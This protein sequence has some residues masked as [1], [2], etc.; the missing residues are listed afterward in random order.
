[1]MLNFIL[2]ELVKSGRVDG[3]GTHGDVEH[4]VF[5][6]DIDFARIQ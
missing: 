5:E 1:M 3:F 6:F 4:L 2:I